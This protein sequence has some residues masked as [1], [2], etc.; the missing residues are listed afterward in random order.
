MPSHPEPQP[1][2]RGIDQIERS[3]AQDAIRHRILSFAM[4]MQKRYPFDFAPGHRGVDGERNR[5]KQEKLVTHFI[6]RALIQSSDLNAEE[7]SAAGELICPLVKQIGTGGA[8][9]YP[10]DFNDLERALAT[11]T[12]GWGFSKLILD[13]YELA[14]IV[15]S[16][17]GP[18]NSAEHSVFWSFR[19]VG[20]LLKAAK[21]EGARR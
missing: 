15:Q 13:A 10:R 19:Y 12:T 16:P 11:T 8:N 2:G 1:T 9:F 14:R 5:K 3:E 20:Q 6:L 21:W 4:Q 18:V 17:L 7:K